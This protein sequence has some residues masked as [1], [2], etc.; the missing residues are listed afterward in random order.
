MKAPVI[1]SSGAPSTRALLALGGAL[2]ALS[3]YRWGVPLAAWIAPAP[4]L[5]VMRRAGGWR[6][7]LV[8]LAVLL[9]ATMVQVGKIVTAPVPWLM[10]FPFA[11]PSALTAWAILLGTEA[12]RRRAGELAG[13]A[14]FVALTGLGEWASYTFSPLGLWGTAASTQVDDLALLQLAAV[15]GV[16]GIGMVVA[17]VPAVLAMLAAAPRTRARVRAA[18]VAA[19]IVGGVHAGGAV[20][21]FAHAG[22]PTLRV[23]AVVTD[24]GLDASGLPS[25]ATLAANE[26]TLFARTRTAAARGAELVVWNEVATLVTPADEARLVARG[27]D[28][29]RALGVELVLAYGVVER[30]APLLIDNKYVWLG[31]DGA[32]VETY[33]K[34]HPV[35]GEPSRRG[36]APLVAHDHPWGRAA[37]AICYDYDFPAIARAHG[38]LGADLVVV[39]SSDWR[40]IDPFHTQIAR[41]GAI[42]GGFALVRSV[43]WATS[44]AFDAYGRTR[45][46]MAVGE[47]NDR[48]MLATVPVTRVPT[49]YARLG[50]APV[51]AVALA[52]LAAV[53]VRAARR[54]RR[55]T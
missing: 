6:P 16:A 10:V 47:H 8:V 33:R 7:R 12:A 30:T 17:V 21:L 40:G 49:L 11:V 9:A 48:I 13:V 2:V 31:T 55:V 36:T 3:A 44:A 46:T 43:R 29:A 5:V 4:F 22:G 28:A 1:S 23:A 14:T 52:L 15:A 35:P 53:M 26:D 18:V 51:V 38:R 34:H 19:A 20:R 41:I 42:S 24:L 50:D 45:A 39:P 27:Q 32:V 54:R 37:G 25:P